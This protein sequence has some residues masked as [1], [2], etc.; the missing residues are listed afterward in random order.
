MLQQFRQDKAGLAEEIRGLVEAG[1]LDAARRL[2]HTNKSI[3][4]HLGATQLADSARALEQ[5]LNDGDEAAIGHALA[6]F[7]PATP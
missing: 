2:A 6:E 1:D 4:A 5:A 3:A 7:Y